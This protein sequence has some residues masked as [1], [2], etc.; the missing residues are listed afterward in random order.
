[1]TIAPGFTQWIPLP[2]GDFGRILRDPLGFQL[3]ARERF[4]DVVRFRNGPFLIHFLYHPDHVRLVLHDRQRN[5]LRSWQ[6]RLLQR[7]F[8]DNLVVSEGEFWMRERRLA[9]PAFHRERLAKYAGIMADATNRLLTRWREMAVAGQPFDVGPEMS[10][11]ALEIAGRTLFSRDV[12]GEADAVGNAFAVVG[13]YLERRFNNALS[14]PPVWVPTPNNAR[15]KAARRTLN[16]IVMGFIRERRRAGGDEGDLLSMLIQVRDEE[17]GEQMTDDQI[18]SEALTF[19]IAGHETTATALTW[20]LFLLASNSAIRQRVRDEVESVLGDRPPTMADL[21]RLGTTRM[22]IEESMRLYPPIWAIT[23]QATADDHLGG[24]HIP[25]RSMIV[26]S[27]FVTHR[28]PDFWEEPARFDPDRFNPERAAK[29]PKCAYF[30]FL[31]GP[32]QCI[33]NEFAMFEMRLI[34]ALTL[35]QFDLELMPDQNIQPK[36]SLTLR[37][38][39]PVRIKLRTLER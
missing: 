5:Y 10:R 33:G 13:R 16:E 18:R 14:S 37:P 26:L 20:T 9:Q 28:H 8:G 1:M 27:P 15:F 17:T 38:N 4:G 36:A 32:H 3:R 12:S 7:L 19:L 25:A 24:F 23:R 2:C 30:P 6:Y 21:P 34:V 39:L 31:A 22:V 11:L 29:R 35:R